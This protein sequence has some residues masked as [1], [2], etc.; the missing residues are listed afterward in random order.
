MRN[1]RVFAGAS[2]SAACF[3]S[4]VLGGAPALSQEATLLEA[5]GCGQ[6]GGQGGAAKA[7]LAAA[8]PDDGRLDVLVVGSSSTAGVGAG[9]QGAAY[10]AVLAALLEARAEAAGASYA[11]RVEPRG[12]S[13]ERA[14]G[15][16]AR[17]ERELDEIKPDLL[18]WQVGTNDAVGGVPLDRLET[19]LREG[20]RAA[21]SHGA[22]VVLVDPQYYPKIS[23]S[24]AYAAVVERIAAVADETGT[25]VVKRFERMRGAEEIG[26]E[27]LETLLA[28]DRFHMSPLGHD[29]LARDL[30]ETILPLDLRASL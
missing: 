8:E 18:V 4:L 19:V 23:G 12:V 21:E 7:S 29:C 5:L 11:I 20:L 28:S 6:G 3:L 26:A 16:L 22:A 30:A 2:L 10:P 17:L 25:P 13:G 1:A 15:A 9:A 14:E 24:A 27:A